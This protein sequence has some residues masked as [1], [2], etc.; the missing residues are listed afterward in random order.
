TLRAEDIIFEYRYD[1]EGRLIE[2]K[3]P[4]KGW[5][6]LVYDPFDRMALTQDAIMREKNQWAFSKVDRIGRVVYTGLYIDSRA[7]DELQLIYDAFEYEEGNDAYYEQE[8]TAIEGYSNDVFP[9][10]NLE[11]LTV[12]YYD[13]YDH[14]SSW[15]MGPRDFTNP[16]ERRSSGMNGSNQYIALD[17][18]YHGPNSIDDLTVE[19]WVN[20]SFVGGDWD[21]WAIIDFDRS[22]YFNLFVNGRTGKL[23]FSTRGGNVHDFYSVQAINDGQWH[24][25]A[26]VFDGTNKYIYIDGVLDRQVG[27]PHNGAYLGTDLKRYGFIGDGSEATTF[28]GSRNNRYF[29][30]KI[31]DVRLWHSVRSADEIA[32]YMDVPIH[33]NTAGLVGKWSMSEVGTQVADETGNGNDGTNFNGVTQESDIRQGGSALY[34]IDDTRGLLTGSM[35]KSGS[36]WLYNVNY[37]DEKSRLVQTIS[38]NH[39]GG[40][41]VN[42]IYYDDF[43]SRA[44]RTVQRLDVNNEITQVTRRFDFDPRGRLLNSFHQINNGATQRI[45]NL[46]YNELNRL[47][48]KNIGE[49]LQSIDYYFN[50]RGWLK[51]INDAALSDGEADLFGM[52]LLYVDDS[53]GL[54]N[55]A[56]YNG[57]ISAMKWSNYDT[58]DEGISERAYAYTYDYSDRLKGATQQYKIA[59]WAP[60]DGF[61]VEGTQYDPNGNITHI[62]RNKAD[63]SS[64]DDLSYTYSGNQLLEVS[65]AAD[66]VGFA[67]DAIVGDDYAYDV[68]GNMIRDLNKGIDTIYYNHLDL[69]V[70]I[71]LTDAAGQGSE[72][73]INP[74]SLTYRYTGTGTKLSMQV[75]QGGSIVSEVDYLG[76]FRYEDGELHSIMHEEGRIVLTD[77]KYDYQYNLRDHQGNTRRVLSTLPEVYT[78]IEDFEDQMSNFS[79]LHEHTTTSGNTTLGGNKASLL[80]SGM[81]GAL[82]MLKM[83]RGDTI[84]LSVNASYETNPDGNGFTNSAYNALFGQWDGTIGSGAEGGGIPNGTSGAFDNAF[85]DMGLS[86]KGSSVAPRAFLN[87][88][89][90]DLDMGYVTSGFQQIS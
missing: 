81:N 21:N 41:E 57:N 31:G 4:G 64:M 38:S 89:I 13:D 75:W 18:F 30:G 87:Y 49:N 23:G 86:D 58:E 28:N 51:G 44:E 60:T 2:R 24:H 22:E 82:V 29:Q 66:S 63:G 46:E 26:A 34:L 25:V 43:T 88:I 12:N 11:L 27:N 55:Q 19:A 65:D 3:V 54:G 7:R 33:P 85:T 84:D 37:Y 14:Q 76:N 6:H 17:Q 15:D 67:D 40:E 47:I 5:E 69:P 56:Q 45:A 70:R 32:E 9:S 72:S 90:F 35:V 50:S 79:E 39:L 73:V 83:D 1:P 48:E 8:G 42:T 52:E 16:D 68:N 80:N 59:S 10:S 53:E 62:N 74:D 77:S 78:T 61:K 20:T 71:E 36:D